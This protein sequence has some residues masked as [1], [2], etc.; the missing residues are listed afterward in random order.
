MAYSAIR[1]KFKAF[2]LGE[3]GLERD[4]CFGETFLIF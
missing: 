2:H 4:K 1:W 3:P